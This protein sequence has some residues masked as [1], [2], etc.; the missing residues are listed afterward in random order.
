MLKNFLIENDEIPWDALK[1]MTGS[2][3]YGGN[4]TD[5]FDRI[6][7][8]NILNIFQNDDIVQIA[9]YKFSK[10]GTYFV[11]VHDKIAQ[12]RMHIEKM[13]NQDEPEI[14]GMHP[15]ANIAY[16]RSESQKLLDTVLN[17]QPREQ[18]SESGESPERQILDLIERLQREVPEPV[19]RDM[20]AKE[21]LKRDSLGLLHCLS[22]VLLQETHRYN[23][24]LAEITTS[25]SQLN[26]AIMGR[27]NMSA[28]LDAMHTDLMKNR[29]PNN[30]S[31]V[32][33][34]SLKPLAP[35][36]TDLADRVQFMR[37]W[38]Q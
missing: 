20:F 6:L 32:S 29:V 30:W 15:N 9:N 17:V 37:R 13:P 16:L 7:M 4:V 18:S 25:L 19:S 35:W 38:A 23:T 31:E 24:L 5:D 36:M 26:D 27:I 8:L 11:P 1:F 22:T 12:M 2:I 28:V 14:F 33:Y 3:N 10:S 21:I 34:P